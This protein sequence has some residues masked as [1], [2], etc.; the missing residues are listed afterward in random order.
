MTN[1]T[2]TRLKRDLNELSEDISRALARADLHELKR[3]EQLHAY[4]ARLYRRERVWAFI[5]HCAEPH[6]ALPILAAASVPA[7]WVLWQ[8]AT[9]S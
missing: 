6:V 1:A 3:L 7:L 2:C 4:Y 8:L 5:E 9:L